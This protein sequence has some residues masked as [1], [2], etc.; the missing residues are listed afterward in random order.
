MENI[1][2]KN[3]AIAA[4]RRAVLTRLGMATVGA[5][6]VPEL[7]LLSQARAA[8]SASPPS[9]PTVPTPPTPPTAPSNIEEIER[10]VKKIDNCNRASSTNPSNEIVVRR[11]DYEKAA[12]SVSAGYA[13]PLNQIWGD[14]ARAY[15]GRIVGMQFT[16]FKWRPRYRLRAISPVGRLETVIVSARTGAIVRIVGC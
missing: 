14:I 11:R 4:S 5:Y 3:M 7:L 2:Q 12:A 15:P 6:F 8:S 10:D 13:K 9:E 16:G 1:D